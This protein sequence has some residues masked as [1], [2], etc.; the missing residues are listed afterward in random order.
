MSPRALRTCVA[1][2][3]ASTIVAGCSGAVGS[4]AST[5]T[6]TVALPTARPTLTPRPTPTLAAPELPRPNQ[7]VATP[8]PIIYI[9]QAGDTLIPIANR[10]GVSVADLIAANG[11]LDATRLQIGQRLIIPQATRSASSDGSLLPSPTPVPY[12]IRGLNSIRSPSGSLDVMGEVFNPGPTGMSNVKVLVTL[13]DE[14]GNALQSASASIPLGVVP[15]GQVSPFRVLFTDPPQGFAKFSVTPLRAEAADPRTI[16]V[17]LT[18]R[19][20]TG[21]PEGPQF[22]ATGEIVNATTDT[23]NRV[24]LMVTIYDPERRVVGYRYF[25]LSEAPLGPNGV[26]PFD[27]LLTTATPNV[28]SFAVYAEGVR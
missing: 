2:L 20:V 8:T 18:I 22:R 28:A 19:S 17:P 21:R 1:G 10:F 9:V 13:Q 23:A 14:A 24:R 27:A 5:P 16:I 15:A 7:P 26:L 6:P 11:N 12:E 25:T 3:L 4:D